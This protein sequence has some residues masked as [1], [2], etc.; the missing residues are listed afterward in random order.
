MQHEIDPEAQNSCNDEKN[1]KPMDV[2]DLWSG[3]SSV[4]IN[5]EHISLSNKVV[6]SQVPI[7]EWTYLPS[8]A[9]QTH[10]LPQRKM[11]P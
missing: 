1:Q 8:D 6:K 9:V 4:G 10:L 7:D 5:K 11:I 2:E 3:V